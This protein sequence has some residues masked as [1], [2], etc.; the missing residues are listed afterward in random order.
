MNNRSTR[1]LIAE[2]NAIIQKVL[3]LTLEREGFTPHFADNGRAAVRMVRQNTYD[4]ILMDVHMPFLD[5]CEA[6][7]EIRDLEAGSEKYTPVIALSGSVSQQDIQLCTASGMDGFLTKPVKK[8]LL[9]D[10]IDKWV[11]C[12]QQSTGLN[13]VG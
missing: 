10:T 12:R 7:R 13:A 3:K 4:L 2:D 9:L 1:I 11:K 8:E 5:G 6:T